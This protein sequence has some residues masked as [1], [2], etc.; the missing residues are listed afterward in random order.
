MASG[1]PLHDIVVFPGECELKEVR[2]TALL[3][4]RDQLA[5]ARNLARDLSSRDLADRR[6]TPPALPQPLWTLRHVLRTPA[7]PL[8]IPGQARIYVL[9]FKEDATRNMFFW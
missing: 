3:Y 1:P 9:E 4:T 8:Q 7:C 5:R 6:R 2:D